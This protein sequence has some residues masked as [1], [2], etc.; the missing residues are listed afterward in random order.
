MKKM[1]LFVPIF[2]LLT[3]CSSP[4]WETVEDTMDVSAAS[5]VESGYSIDIS[6]P[7]GMECLCSEPGWEIYSTANGDFEV[8]TRAFLASDL[9]TAVYMLTGYEA[10]Q[11]NILQTE[12]FDLPEYQFAWVTCT[13]Q[14]SK[15]C[16]ADMVMDGTD[17]YAVVC[18]SLENAG[19]LYASET[20]RVISA[21]GLYT[22]EGV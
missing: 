14:G 18:S 1:L 8:E 9:N 11:M 5:W 13:E 20:R 7:Q 10:S 17:C 16:R 6:L 15:L 12:R 2:L 21:F 19:D 22:D 4:V 3:G